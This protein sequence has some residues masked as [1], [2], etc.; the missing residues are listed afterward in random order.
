LRPKF[1]RV[2]GAVKGGGGVE[3]AA[4]AAAAAAAVVTHMMA[5]TDTATSIAFK[6]TAT[7]TSGHF[8]YQLQ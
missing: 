2:A 8:D 1:N 3:A 4:A 6:C 7:A 5:N